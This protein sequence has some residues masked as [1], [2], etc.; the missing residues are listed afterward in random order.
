M[1]RALDVLAMVETRVAGW[2][3]RSEETQCSAER[4]SI[5]M[6]RRCVDELCDNVER[7]LSKNFSGCRWNR[8]VQG[9]VLAIQ[10]K[11]KA[12]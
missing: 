2:I 12:K 7:A 5:R 1:Q 8:A 3:L 10:M 6:G 11:R 9:G 4:A